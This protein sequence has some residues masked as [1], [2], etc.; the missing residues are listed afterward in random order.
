MV[1]EHRFACPFKNGL[2]ARP[3]SQI[4]E[5][6]RGF[7]SRMTLG[8]VGETGADARSVLSL[9]GLGI[10]FGEACVLVCD[11]EDAERAAG[12]LLGLIEGRLAAEDLASG[13]AEAGTV[14]S[15]VG[16]L[17]R[18]LRGDGVRLVRGRAVSAGIGIG[19]G[20]R[21]RGVELTAAMAAAASA[22]LEPELSAARAAVGAVDAELRALA[23]ASRRGGMGAGTA[24]ADVLLAHAAMVADPALWARIERAVGGGKTAAQAVV[25]A[26]RGLCESL[27]VAPSAYIRD[28]A[29][30]VQDV[31]LRLLGHLGGSERSPG[32]AAVPKLTGPSVVFAEA[33]TPGQLLG[34]DRGNIAGLV[35][36]TVGETSHT[37]IL[38]RMLQVPTV[39]GA[40]EAGRL[41]RDGEEVIVDAECG[42][43]VVGPSAE[44]RGHYQ[45]RRAAKVRRLERLGPML[46]AKAVTADGVGI[47]IGV[48]ASMPG[49][50]SGAAGAD[51]VGLLRT[52]M[53]FLD[54]AVAP[55]EDEQLEVYR[56]IV[57]EA[58]GRS[59]IIRTFDIGGD[60]PAA[61]LGMAREENPFLGVRGMRLYEGHVG[62]LRTQLR[63]A[64]RAAAA[65]GAS[66]R[67]MAPM[68]TTVAEAAWFRTQVAEAAAELGA[69]GTEHRGDVPVGMMVEVPA[70]AL[71]VDKLA[72]HAD[73]FSL[74]TNDLSQYFFAADRGNHGVAELCDPREPSMLRLLQETVARARAAGR[75]I[76]VCGEMAGEVEN[77]PLTIGLGVDEISVSPGRVAV[78]KQAV[79]RA[80]AAACRELLDRATDATDAEAV[81]SML[82]A[83]GWRVAGA[84]APLMDAGLIDVSLS[85]T[86]KGEAIDRLVEMLYI[87]G[88]TDDPTALEDAV[89]AREET[90]STGLGHGFAVPHCKSDAVMVPTLAVARLSTA[91]E[92]GSMDGQG[93]DTVMLLAVP[94]S[95]ESG[96]HLKIFAK[97]ARRLMHEAFRDRLRC[98]GTGEAVADCLREELGIE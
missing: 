11:G 3:A 57:A 42:A 2:H 84:A 58:A 5:A 24:E 22:G 52:E 49:D 89:W 7:A 61:Y 27:G 51:G 26:S 78:L 86:S 48:N 33:L 40:G 75:W 60:K 81:S 98:A 54:R 73:F 90:Y 18:C 87:A 34:L 45:R 77:L 14:G 79:G 80:N 43:A 47:E 4:A 70:A 36:G 46:K 66:V 8:R 28:R 64:L 53:L 13:A 91:V 62:L 31:S 25:E 94:A 71:I 69:E 20:V 38:A 50:L 17:P 10:G 23:A 15:G 83:G 56:A 76:G 55:T 12:V 19:V 74:G 32:C 59:V 37:V 88:R 93:V 21:V 82:E 44:V 95:D 9:I 29:I 39:I 96:A 35:L 85:A 68:V 63:A 65:E 97:L 30:D 16:A 1:V 67:I 72:A 6:A 41:L 92:W